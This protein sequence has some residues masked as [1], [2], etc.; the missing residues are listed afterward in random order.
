VGVIGERDHDL[1]ARS[2]KFPMQLEYRL[3]RV[4]DDLRNI[5]AGLDVAAAL[6]F[7]DVA[8]GAEDDA[9]SETLPKGAG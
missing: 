6:E 5:G 9:L 8:L 3:R 1:S 2:Q 7:E 4:E